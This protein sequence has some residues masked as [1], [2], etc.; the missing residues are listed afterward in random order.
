M[1]SLYPPCASLLCPP[2]PSLCPLRHALHMPSLCPPCKVLGWISAASEAVHQ[3]R[4]LAL[5][6]LPFVAYGM[7]AVCLCL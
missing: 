2:S 4:A 1:P 3:R 5:C 7:V 6:L